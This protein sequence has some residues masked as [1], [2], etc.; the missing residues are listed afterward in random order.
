MT[1]SDDGK[2]LCAAAEGTRSRQQDARAEARLQTRNRSAA[3]TRRHEITAAYDR[4]ALGISV[5]QTFPQQNR[6]TSPH[7]AQPQKRIRS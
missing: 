6:W 1:A 5:V 3:V 4:A 7:P 2:L